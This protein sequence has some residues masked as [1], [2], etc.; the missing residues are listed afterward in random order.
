MPGGRRA[1]NRDLAACSLAT[2]K[3]FA[4]AAAAAS[5]S[6]RSVKG[7]NEDETFRARV[8][9]LRAEM[10]GRACGE[11][12]DAMSAAAR[13]LRSLVENGT[14]SIALRASVALIASALRVTELTVLQNRVEQLEQL[15]AER[16]NS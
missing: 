11:L 9:G 15:L 13:K 12:A 8:A 10:I 2:G 6:E 5:V 16:T 1:A 14:D 3:T 7:W 4:E